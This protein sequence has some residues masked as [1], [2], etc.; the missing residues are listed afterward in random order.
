MI[1]RPDLGGLTVGLI[2]TGNMGRPIARH[3]HAAGARLLVHNRS[4]APLRE[5]ADAGMTVVDSPEAMAADAEIVVLTVTDS[6]AV[7]TVATRLIA[8]LAEGTLI[9]D[10]GTTRA[11]ITRQLAEQARKRGGDWVDAPVSGG[12]V[13]AQLQRLVVMA[14]GT[15]T[16]VLR[17]MPVLETVAER[18]T[19]VGDVG[20]GQIAK[21]ANQVIVGLTIQAVA[22]AFAMARAA[23]VDPARVRE[24][25]LGGFAGSRILDLHGHRMAT[26][27]YRPGARVTIQEKDMREAAEFGAGLG[28]EMPATRLCRDLYQRLIDRGLA[29]LDHAALLKLWD[30]TDGD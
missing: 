15:R 24:A 9:L 27:D 6:A 23:G 19:H 18:I 10:M 5:L 3:L 29:D 30:E 28:V 7:Q 22:E 26:G 11:E 25:L 8:N 21:S 16:A 1:A 14:G 17:A 4:D 13:G 12:E 20:A 2:G